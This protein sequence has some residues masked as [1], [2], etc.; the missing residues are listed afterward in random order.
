MGRRCIFVL[1][2]FVL[3]PLAA[4][5]VRIT[6]GVT[7]EQVLQRNSR[8]A[9]DLNLTGTVTG[10]KN[11]GK[12]IEARITASSNVLPNFEWVPVGKV[13]KQNFAA[14][15]IGIPTGG[16]Y[17]IELR[18]QGGASVA[19]VYNILVGDLWILAGQ[20]NMEGVG[21]L[22]D[23]QQPDLM[24]H[25]FDLADHWGVAEEPLHTLVSAVDRVHWRNNAQ[26]L[27]ERW[28]GARLQRYV[29][30]RKKG[31][32]LGLPFAVNMSTRTGI[33]IGLIPC[34]HGGTSM[35]QWSPSL[36]DREGDSLYGSMVRRFKATGGRV[37]GVLWYQGESDANEKAA[38]AFLERFEGF[39]KAVRTDF[40]N[41]ELPFYYV[42]IGRHVSGMNPIEWN[43]VQ[44]AQRKAE[45]QIPQSGMVAAVDLSLDD[46]IH[47]STPDLKRIARRLADRV[48]HDL[49]PRLKDYGE[50]KPGPRPVSAKYEN[51]LVRVEFSD[52]NG[53]LLS[54]G[55][56]SGFSIHQPDGTPV[57]M[58]Y[59]AR[60]DPAEA[61]TVLLYVGGKLPENATLHYGYGKDPYCNLRDA[62]DNAVPVFGPMA[63]Q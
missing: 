25:S 1:C 55:R 54:E 18:M 30:E 44:E 8:Q 20:S 61:S 6:G 59:K 17:R 58:I 31:A 56:I 9:A 10:K 26:G 40:K 16:P 62:N 49:F 14:N 37:T 15:L 32:G 33:P 23:V 50:L 24:V 19:A 35:E 52:V 46:G 47:V 63:I 43:M 3:L 57:P 22:I 12:V 28:T 48:C 2:C 42:Q 53:R 38:P 29:R 51:G 27:P 4:Q 39:V 21:D 60:V 45:F 13:Q 5:D 36:K 7:D 34:A 11:N 41:A